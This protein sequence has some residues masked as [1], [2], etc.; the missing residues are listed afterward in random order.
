[1]GFALSILYFITYYLGPFTVFGSL[2]A[3][4]VALIIAALAIVVSLPVLHGPSS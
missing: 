3:Y 1:M 2:A 4:N